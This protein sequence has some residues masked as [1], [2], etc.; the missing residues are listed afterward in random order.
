MCSLC[1][2]KNSVI[3][4]GARLPRGVEG[5]CVPRQ[6]CGCG[7]DCVCDGRHKLGGGLFLK[8]Q[9]TSTSQ[10][11]AFAMICCG[12]DDRVEEI[13]AADSRL[14]GRAVEETEGEF[15][16]KHCNLERA[17]PYRSMDCRD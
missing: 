12:R 17:I 10:I 14:R 1:I 3:P 9:G 2:V 15:R 8:T 16:P 13:T 7:G 5:P 4:N 6:F 11:I